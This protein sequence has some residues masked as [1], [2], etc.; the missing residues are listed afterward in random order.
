MN[1][2]K[3]NKVNNNFGRKGWGIILYCAILMYFGGAINTYGGSQFSNQIAQLRG[4][5][6][7]SILKYFTYGGWIGVVISILAAAVINKKG[8][9]FVAIIGLVCGGLAV[10]LI[11]FAS[12]QFS[13]AAC[14]IVSSC[15]LVAYSSLVPNTLMNSWFP[16]TKGIALGWSTMGYPAADVFFTS[17]FLLLISFGVKQGFVALGFMLIIVA[18]CTKLFVKNTPEEANAYPDNDRSISKEELEKNA[19]AL[20]SY[21]SDW[22]IVNGK[23]QVLH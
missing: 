11:G 13:Y 8:A 18:I 2:T 15:A 3:K 1:N 10:G 6:Y 12:T 20:K 16:K 4:W 7:A 17:M 5:D 23:P 19:I 9:K 21:K 22:T 14:I